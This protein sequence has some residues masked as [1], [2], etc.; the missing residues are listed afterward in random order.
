L[1]TPV[2]LVRVLAA[3]VLMLLSAS[4]VGLAGSG[5]RT[6]EVRTRITIQNPTDQPVTDLVLTLPSSA[7]DASGQRLGGAP[8]RSVPTGVRTRSSRGGTTFEV[9]QVGPGGTLVIEEVLVVQ[10]GAAIGADA[11]IAGP[12]SAG[13]GATADQKA[14]LVADPVQARYLAAEPGVEADQPAISAAARSAVVGATGVDQQAEALLRAVVDHVDYD[15]SGAGGGAL[16]GFEQG[17][18]SCQTYASLFVAMARAAGI[19]ARLVYGWADSGGLS[20]LLGPDNR[21]VWAEYY[22]PDRGWVPVD[23]TFAER[24]RDLLHFDPS[25]HLAQGYEDVS[26]QASFGGRGFVTIRVAREVSMR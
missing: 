1:K 9:A 3:A 17:L 13:A 20:G 22:N 24:Q 7:A 11:A 16:A 10:L 26:H 15:W 4:A 23:P 8:Q 18:G 6:V 19:P 25:A 14:T 21:H 12:G 5:H 2:R